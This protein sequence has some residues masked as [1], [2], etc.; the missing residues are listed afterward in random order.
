MAL[1][2]ALA[3]PMVFAA[4]THDSVFVVKK[5]GVVEA[6]AVK[7]TTDK[8][9][10]N[11]SELFYF[12]TNT[13]ESTE[14]TVS[15]GFEVKAL[16]ESIK[17]FATK[18]VEV[19]VAYSWFNKEP[20]YGRDAI[21]KLG[22][23]L[24]SDAYTFTIHGLDHGVT[25]YF[26][27]YIKIM[28]KVYYSNV[29][30]EQATTGEEQTLSLYGRYWMNTKTAIKGSTNTYLNYARYNVG[31]CTEGNPGTYFAWG[32]TEPA[33][34][35]TW[36][37]YKWGDGKTM[38]KYVPGGES[39]SLEDEDNPVREHMD[40]IMTG[41]DFPLNAYVYMS[42]SQLNWA[43]STRVAPDGKTIHGIEVYGYYPDPRMFIPAGGYYNGTTLVGYD[44]LALLWT[45][46]TYGYSATEA[47]VWFSDSTGLKSPTY[48]AGSHRERYLGIPVRA[49][50][51][52]SAND[53]DDD[54]DG[55]G[56]DDD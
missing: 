22:T 20:A 36:D 48:D 8:I 5:S 31:S 40:T 35:Y 56:G 38:T 12:T 21:M 47:R 18:I 32:D 29:I 16:D 53:A 13:L 14:S 7:N 25:Y 3:A 23:E 11:D 26:R 55:D 19:G 24:K 52:E 30:T 17:S 41:G 34:E 54:G 43:W 28:G 10:F 1:G 2:L 33:D 45:T 27:P 9:F 51:F 49:A 4:E 15:G 42:L 50:F 37:T 6:V 44:D 39:L 46:E